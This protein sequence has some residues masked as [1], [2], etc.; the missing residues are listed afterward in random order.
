MN[1]KSCFLLFFIF[2]VSCGRVL[3]E[4]NLSIFRYNQPSGI[5]TLDPAFAKDQAT[6]WACNQLFNGLVQLNNNLEVVPSIAKSWKISE[7]G[8]VYT[9]SIRTDVKFHK[10]H[11]ISDNRVVVASDFTYSLDRLK[12]KR[13]ASPGVWILA[14]VANYYSSNDSTFL[15]KLIKPFPPFL[16]LLTMQYCSVVPKEFADDKK[17]RDKPIGTGPF[18]F[19]YWKEGVKLVFRKNI[20]YFEKD[21]EFNLPYLD[22]VAITFIKDK[23]TAFLEFI[24][25]NLDFISGI[26]ASYKDQIL[27]R[28]G[29][30]QE[31]YKGKIILQSSPYLNTEYLGFLMDDSVSPI[32]YLE[33]RQA[34]NYGFDRKKMLNYLRNNIGTPALQGF[35]PQGLPSFSENINGYYYSPEKAKK[36]LKD[37]GFENGKKIGKIILSTTSSYLDLCEY[38]QQQLNEIGLDV[39]IQVNTSSTHRQMVATSKLSF[40]R[41][42]WIA[43]YADAENYLALFY[44]KNFCPDG[45]N[46]THFKSDKYDLLY[47]KASH[48]ILDSTRFKLYQEMDEMILEQAAIVPLYYDRVLRFCQPNIYGFNSNSMNLLDLKRVKK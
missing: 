28:D 41:G 17:F 12:D 29:K 42:S 16:G 27:Q 23:Q 3:H 43:D 46:Y 45:P 48:E 15:I 22:A 13:L 31:K 20:D 32:K 37:V 5:S 33:V 2:F 26:D 35:V 36:L 38:I 11:L 8:L 40:F 25:G 30:L 7:D 4:E 10:H 19:Q 34:I 1:I 44:S 14:N 9:F 21:K 6:I 39:V 18:K 24:K 47:E